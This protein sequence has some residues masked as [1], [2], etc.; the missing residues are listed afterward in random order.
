MVAHPSAV[1]AG[2]LVALGA[3][4]S[5]VVPVAAQVLPDRHVQLDPLAD[6]A[7]DTLGTTWLT[8]ARLYAEFARN[9]PGDADHRWV[10]RTGGVAELVRWD[11][12]ASLMIVGTMEVVIDPNNDI[13]FNPRAIFWEEGLMAGFGLTRDVSLQA[14]YIHRCKHDI[15][16]LEIVELDRGREQRTLIYSGVITRLLVRDAAIVR[17][18]WAITGSGSVRNDF[19]LHL[20]D[21]RR[22]GATRGVGLDFESMIDAL[23]LSGRIEAGPAGAPWRVHATAAVMATAFGAE[24]GFSE[25]FGDVTILG[26]VPFVE[27]GIDLV[28]PVGSTFTLFARGEWQR[29][30]GIRSRPTGASLAMI[31]V[32]LSDTRGIW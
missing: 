9:T 7:L 19:F 1:A 26:S 24:R 27:L 28:N 4:P 25:R 29:D 22:D 10:A 6:H 31:G 20:L 21:D 18:D 8:G 2:L 32:R 23:T 30:A 13:T 17:G 3:S 16:N 11:S 14:G 5:G 15:D 12:S